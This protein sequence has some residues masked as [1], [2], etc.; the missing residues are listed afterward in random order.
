VPGGEVKGLGWAL[1]EVGQEVPA[2]DV[3]KILF[4]K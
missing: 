3:R 1:R 2:Q 4:E